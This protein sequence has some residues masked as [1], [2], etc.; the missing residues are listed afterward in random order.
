MLIKITKTYSGQ[1]GKRVK[2]GRVFFAGNPKEAPAGFDEADILTTERGKQL[3]GVNLAK[4]IDEPTRRAA[5]GSKRP[6][7]PPGRKTKVEPTKRTQK[8]PAKSSGQ[9]VATKKKP[10]STKKS[11]ASGNDPTP[12]APKK[13]KGAQTGSRTGQGQS[14][15]SSG[16]GRQTSGSTSGGQKKKRGQRSGGSAS[17]TP[18]DSSKGQTSSTDATPDGGASTGKKSAP[19]DTLD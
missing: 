10:A 2:A 11:K 12:A 16:A 4:R 18:T 6:A 17:T 9:T 13:V 1:E 19:E 14:A 15:S 7:S 5:P 3:I 8:E